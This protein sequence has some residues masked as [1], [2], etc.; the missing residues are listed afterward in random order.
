MELVRSYKELERLIRS[1][2]CKILGLEIDSTAVRVQ[3][4]RDG[5]LGFKIDDNVLI[6][7]MN[8]ARD[9]FSE[10]RNINYE[11][12][13]E[14]VYRI[15]QGTRVWEVTLVAYGPLAYEWL[16]VIRSRSHDISIK[17]ML[18]VHDVYI[19]PNFPNIVRAPELT[20]GQW[21]NRCDMRLTFN[22]LYIYE[23]NVGRIDKVTVE[24]KI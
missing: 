18:S 14:D 16:D 1:S 4:Q 20:G 17:S 6:M 19:V 2:F 13:G 12:R 22:E 11:D 8:E 10:Q 7:T 15:H 3:F 5:T 24:P 9:S 23:E 21:W